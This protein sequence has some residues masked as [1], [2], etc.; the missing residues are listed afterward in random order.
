MQNDSSDDENKN[1]LLKH[2]K[3]QLVKVKEEEKN[4]I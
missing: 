2:F 3:I 1:N 4:L